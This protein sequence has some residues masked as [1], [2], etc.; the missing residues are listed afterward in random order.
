MEGLASLFAS[1]QKN[2]NSELFPAA[3][4]AAYRIPALTA[5]P[6]SR[7]VEGL[8][9]NVV[10]GVQYDFS[11]LE[12][13]SLG[14]LYQQFAGLRWAAD[15][16]SKQL[17]LVGKES[18]ASENIR[19]QFGVF[20]T[21]PA[22]VDT[23]LELTLGG[24]L[25]E[26]GPLPTQ[27]IPSI[28][29]LTAGS[30]VFLS[31]AFEYI[32]R[33]GG[34]GSREE[35][36]AWIEH[37]HGADIDARAISLARLNLWMAFAR[38]FSEA[39]LPSLAHTVRVADSLADETDAAVVG[40]G[41][42]SLPDEWRSNGFDIVVG[43]PPFLGNRD[44][45]ALFGARRVKMWRSRHRSG[46]KEVNLA[47][48]F[49]ERA[50]R[51]L[52]PGGYLGMVVPRNLIKAESGESL[53]RLIRHSCEVVMVIDCLD[54]KLFS[55]V[56][57]DAAIVILRRP[58]GNAGAVTSGVSLI[59]RDAR[60]D[61]FAP[62]AMIRHAPLSHGLV[63]EHTINLERERQILSGGPASGTYEPAWFLEDGVGRCILERLHEASATGL[64]QIARSMY[65]VDEG[66]RG[67]F[68]LTNGKA[69]HDGTVVAWSAALSASVEI[70]SALLRP[71][72]KPPMIQPLTSR[73]GTDAINWAAILY[74][75]G[76]NGQLVPW[77]SIAKQLPLT[78]QYLLAL[79]PA[80]IRR[81]GH[82]ATDG[83]WVPRAV[84]KQAPWHRP[85]GT[86]S[87]V[88]QSRHG[89][90]P[91]AM[92]APR[93]S[94]AVGGG[95]AW[96]VDPTASLAPETLMALL[97]SRLW[98]WFIVASGS[99]GRGKHYR[100]RPSV[101]EALRIPDTLRGTSRTTKTLGNRLRK[102]QSDSRAD[103][104]SSAWAA[105]DDLIE[106]AYHLTAAER[107]HLGTVLQVYT[108]L[109]RAAWIH[110]ALERENV[111]GLP[112]FEDY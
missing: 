44:A 52:R 32:V 70:E 38:Q 107:D 4:P 19:D 15:S 26:R 56:D 24:W 58:R 40:E 99:V 67:A 82:G 30:G 87:Y 94:V 96:S 9:L 60:A 2:F 63:L 57:A 76:T 39:K 53:R 81:R 27:S 22:V 61:T 25:R 74:P 89:Q 12:S 16:P 75:Y 93:R 106:D 68:V 91:R 8:Y 71:A 62:L 108:A 100:I 10:A 92:L 17:R 46:T 45:V 59:V 86:D 37:C 51:M 66:L 84:R 110:Q 104:L 31:R 13:D 111:T 50:I 1:L 49:V 64:G 98:W 109:P 69:Q 47:A 65:A 23:I 5:N 34:I 90:W 28:L 112:L 83:W 95:I 72:I 7:F 101:W 33:A 105:V 42:P 73:K 43:N 36:R 20:Y 54:G 103:S 29:D 97:S 11:L 102:L 78:A 41:L 21:P 79:R 3:N 48:L 35:G 77:D 14:L 18:P 88:L 80:L 6:V 85:E 55:D